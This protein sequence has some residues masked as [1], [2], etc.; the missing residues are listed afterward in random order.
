MND[1]KLTGAVFI[2][3]SK[4]FDT[5]S[6]AVLLSKL[7]QYGV[8]SNELEWF[9]D[10]LFN[11]NQVVCFENT[12]SDQQ[13]V[14]SGVPQGSVLG[15]LLFLIHFNDFVLH[16]KH[17]EVIKFAD[18]TIIYV[19]GKDAT[20]IQSK[21]TD[22]MNIIS[23]WLDS[24]DLIMNLKQGKTETMLFGTAKSL[25]KFLN[26]P[27]EVSISDRIINNTSLYKYLGMKLDPTLSHLTHILMRFIVK[28]PA[29]Y[30][31]YIGFVIP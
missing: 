15:P 28:P 25:N 9:S 23:D 14:Y 17:S 12:F 3:L 6:H 31:F 18:D 2:D 20:L 24:N 1:G 5:I 10:Y 29:D 13:P 27:F 21:L 4:A 11:R 30:V 22:D 7:P 16:L 19:R 26:Q 8:T